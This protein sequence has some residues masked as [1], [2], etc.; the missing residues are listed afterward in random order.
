[1]FEQGKKPVAD[2]VHRRFMSGNVEEHDKRHQFG[3]V[4]SIA[5]TLCSEEGR[6][7]IV[8]KVVSALLNDLEEIR[9]EFVDSDIGAVEVVERCGGFES[10]SEE[11]TPI[12]EFVGTVGRH[13]EHCRN[14]LEGN[15]ERKF[16]DD[17]HSSSPGSTVNR[18]VDHLLGCVPEPVD[19]LWGKCLGDKFSEP[20]VV[21]R[22]K[23]EDRL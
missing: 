2:Q 1:M 5:F 21:G 7:D 10:C 22:I 8:A 4:E 17:F 12:T 23:V 16:I 19:C 18:I 14:H 11:L 9:D 15:R 13:V 3:H 20:G 6:D